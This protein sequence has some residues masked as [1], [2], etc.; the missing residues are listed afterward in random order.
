MVDA[1]Q[2]TDMEGLDLRQRLAEID[3]THAE[4]SKLLAETRKIAREA[5]WVPVVVGST[6]MT[7]I[8]GVIGAALALALKLIGN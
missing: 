4:I 6:A 7:A 3:K 8:A 5:T 2:H 1:S